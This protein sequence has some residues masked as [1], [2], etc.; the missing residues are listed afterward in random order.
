MRSKKGHMSD[1][2]WPPVLANLW[3]SIREAIRSSSREPGFES[4]APQHLRIDVLPDQRRC[5]R[6][7]ILSGNIL[8][9]GGA[10]DRTLNT[11]F[12]TF[13]R[14]YSD[15]EEWRSTVDLGEPIAVARSAVKSIPFSLIVPDD[16]RSTENEDGIGSTFARYMLEFSFETESGAREVVPSRSLHVGMH[17]AARALLLGMSRAGFY[18]TNLSEEDG[19]CHVSKRF[20]PVHALSR[21]ISSAELVIAV[22]EGRIAATIKLKP[23][24]HTPAPSSE[25]VTVQIEAAAEDLIDVDGRP[26]ADLARALIEKALADS[27]LI[28]NEES[29]TLLRACSV[30][31]QNL[32]RPVP[33]LLAASENLLQPAMDELAQ[34]DD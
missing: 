29:A 23:N 6:G 18:T 1:E 32:L 34:T 11:P 30:P 15:E 5:P 28:G 4:A 20:L 3:R 19:S 12:L 31:T 13:M 26:D 17:T 21:W 22:K 14:I 9:Q 2:R 33:A 8:L 7:S 25:A 16:A 24:E 10:T 27:M